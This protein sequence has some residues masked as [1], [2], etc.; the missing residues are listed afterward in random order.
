MILL[1]TYST[2]TPPKIQYVVLDCT[3]HAIIY[4]PKGFQSNPPKLVHVS[5]QPLCIREL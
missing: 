3:T 5:K 4:K 1:S 2:I